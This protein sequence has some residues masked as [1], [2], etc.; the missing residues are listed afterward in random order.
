MYECFLEGVVKYL[1]EYT[2][3]AK[4]RHPLPT[5][6]ALD[7]DS[8]PLWADLQKRRSQVLIKK[9]W[10]RSA[11]SF[12]EFLVGNDAALQRHF[13]RRLSIG[14]TSNFSSVRTMIVA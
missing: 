10:Q 11:F 8:S 9:F 14:V 2:R 12:A 7:G 1:V 6:A 5:P 3:V 4:S 13:C